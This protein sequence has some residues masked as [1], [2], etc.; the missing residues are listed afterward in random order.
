MFDILGKVEKNRSFAARPGL[1]PPR[2]FAETRERA[3]RSR[4]GRRRRNCC[5]ARRKRRRSRRSSGADRARDLARRREA[6]LLDIGERLA[7]QGP[8]K[9]PV[10]L[11]VLKVETIQGARMAISPVSDLILDVARAADPQKAGA[12]RASCPTALRRRSI[13]RRGDARGI[14]GDAETSGAVGRHRPL[15]LPQSRRASSRRRRLPRTRRRWASRACC[16]KA[17]S[18]KCCRRTRADVYGSGVAGDVWRSMMSEKIADEVA[19][20]GALENRGPPVRH[21]SGSVAALDREQD[22]AGFAAC[23]STPDAKI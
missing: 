19:K 16:S 12:A 13:R 22:S 1:P 11:S 18:M 15:R 7:E 3:A 20:S 14:F 8:L 23:S 4:S 5:S 10:S 21:A 17:S 2:P 9:P 6:Q